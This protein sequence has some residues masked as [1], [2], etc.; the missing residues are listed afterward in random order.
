MFLTFGLMS[1]VGH[2]LIFNTSV[3]VI[4]QHFMK[5]RSVAVGIVASGPAIGMFV[6]SQ[7]TRLL[8][9][10]FGWPGAMIGYAILYFVCGL[11][12]TMFVTLKTFK[13]DNSD[14]NSHGIKREESKTSSPL[15]NRHFLIMFSSFVI[16]HFSYYVPT[17]HI[18]SINLMFWLID[19][20]AILNCS[21]ITLWYFILAETV[22]LRRER[23]KETYGDVEVCVVRNACR[24]N[25]NETDSKTEKGRQ[26]AKQEGWS[27]AQIKVVVKR[28]E[29]CK[30]TCCCQITLYCEIWT[31]KADRQSD[32]RLFGHSAWR[33]DNGSCRRYDG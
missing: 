15:R 33:K 22:A 2:G 28:Q 17:I 30:E 24:I 18:V 21:L 12:A 20:L 13:E 7:I 9:S 32:K 10:T 25:I 27:V 1:G 23:N 26:T 11:C 31:R 3:L 4:L 6:F 8:L 16:I 29:E 5:W 19:R 14:I